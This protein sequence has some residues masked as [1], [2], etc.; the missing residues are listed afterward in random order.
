MKTVSRR[1]AQTSRLMNETL[2]QSPGL[3]RCQAQQVVPFFP[4]S[5]EELCD[6]LF[7][8]IWDSGRSRMRAG[9]CYGYRFTGQGGARQFGDNPSGAWVT[10]SDTI[11]ADSRVPFIP[12]WGERRQT[13][14]AALWSTTIPCSRYPHSTKHFPFW[15]Q[16]VAAVNEERLRPLKR[17]QA[18]PEKGGDEM[19]KCSE[20]SSHFSGF[21]TGIPQTQAASMAN[22]EVSK[23]R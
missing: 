4:A 18:R 11:E 5:N 3:R 2:V 7:R 23:C 8:C 6:R 12:F 20:T 22:L 16:P 21:S 13:E 1:L 10:S 9:Q 14:H 19:A 15:F 17:D